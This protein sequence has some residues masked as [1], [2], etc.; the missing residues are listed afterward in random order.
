[1]RRLPTLRMVIFC[2]TNS[3]LRDHP[4]LLIPQD[5]RK[6]VISTFLNDDPSFLEQLERT[7]LMK[8]DI[9]KRNKMVYESLLKNYKGDHQKVLKHIR[10]EKFEISKRYSTGAVTI[11][12]QIHVDAQ[13]QQITMD[14]RLA[15]LPPSFTLIYFK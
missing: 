12:P 2:D 8:G 11:E 6:D 3:E 1:M 14:K 15:S 9:S 7:Y 13:L 10:V 4:I 5:Y